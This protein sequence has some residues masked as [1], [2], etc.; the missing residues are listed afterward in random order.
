V[1][2]MIRAVTFEIWRE[3]LSMSKVGSWKTREMD[4]SPSAYYVALVRDHG[5]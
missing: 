1:Q 2:K 4:I 3:F 5:F